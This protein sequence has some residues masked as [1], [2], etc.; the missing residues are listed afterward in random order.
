MARTTKSRSKSQKQKDSSAPKP[1]QGLRELQ[2]QRDSGVAEHA[3]AV[4]TV[5]A[6]EGYI[7]R[8]R[9]F[10]A[11]MV[12]RHQDARDSGCNEESDGLDL[13][14]LAKAFDEP[15]NRYSAEALGLF[16]TQKC[17]TEGCSMST[18]EGIQGAFANFWDNLGGN[19]KFAGEYKYNETTHAVLGCPARA[20]SVKTLLTA[21]RNKSNAKGAAANRNHAEAMSIEDLRRIMQWSEKC[22]PSSWFEV[23]E[24]P[25]NVAEVVLMA[26]HSLFRAFATT[27]FNI[28][29]RNFEACRIQGRDITWDLKGP[30]PHFLDMWSLHLENRK[31]WQKQ[32]GYDG[33]LK[34]NLYHIYKQD[35]DELDLFTHV[36]RH[37][38]FLEGR[39]GRKLDADDYIFPHISANGII[40]PKRQTTHEI[41]QSLIDEFAQGAGVAKKYST[42]CFRRGGAQYRFMFAPIGERWSLSVVRWWG[43][44]AVG[45]HVDTLIKYLVDSLQA[46]ESGHNDALHPIQTGAQQSFMG[47]H[48]LQQ[49]ATTAEVRQST[50]SMARKFDEVITTVVSL[51]QSASH[52][53]PPTPSTPA[54]AHALSP[55]LMMPTSS[56]VSP[57]GVGSIQRTSSFVPPA[58]I[59]SLMP[60]NIPPSLQSNATSEPA[61]IPGTFIPD[62]PHGPGGWQ[63][64]IKQWEESDTSKSFTALKD[65]PIEWYTGSMRKRVAAK[66]S[67]RKIIYE[68]FQRYNRDEGEFTSA[69]P[70]ANQTLT[71][72]I[73]AIRR[74]N[75][76]QR[77]SKNG[78]PEERST[79]PH[80]E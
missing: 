33:P 41:V 28:W 19:G 55:S 40:D 21:V 17:F 71:A 4:R 11:G 20:M 27:G 34:S 32:A 57:L 66:R 1:S 76:K 7:K 5:E 50:A 78:T 46:Y 22:C 26:K 64:A 65:W 29:T 61:P 35:L 15:P 44:W 80:T 72:L 9:E 8:G 79:L 53:P 43:G 77:R 47:D 2:A 14:L 51:F 3:R 62:L 6:Y 38:R 13:C 23:A 60:P 69:Y 74:R 68:E 45:E 24:K 25:A 49:S 30:P 59:N 39:I 63:K 18:A 54:S 12:K 67:T 75:A 16:I 56:T 48:V 52:G 58:L 37:V 10:L 31:G 73:N 36:P 42:H 70:E